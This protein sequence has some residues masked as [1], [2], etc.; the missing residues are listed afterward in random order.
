MYMFTHIRI[1]IDIYIHTYIHTRNIY[2]YIHTYIYICVYAHTYV[3]IYTYLYVYIFIHTYTYTY[4][5]KHIYIQQNCSKILLAL[6][7]CCNQTSLWCT[8]LLLYVHKF[9][10]FVLFICIG[11]SLCKLTCTSSIVLEVKT[12]SVNGLLPIAPPKSIFRVMY[13][14]S[15]A[16][17]IL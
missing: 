8:Q 10:I 13:V 2:I 11:C 3:C 15:A 12:L 4:T 1:Y 6:A 16:P 7:K 9:Y 5:Y 17:C 14:E